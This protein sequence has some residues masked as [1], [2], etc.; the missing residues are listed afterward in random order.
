M[1]EASI[2]QKIDADSRSQV[3]PGNEIRKVSCSQVQPGNEIR[4][5]L[6]PV[7]QDVSVA[8]CFLLVGFINWDYHQQPLTQLS[9]LLKKKRLPQRATLN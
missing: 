7:V 3:Q 5:V 8:T 6:P 9:R 1:D 2:A 4:E